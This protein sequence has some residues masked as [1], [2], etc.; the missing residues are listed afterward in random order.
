MEKEITVIEARDMIKSEGNL[1][2]IDLR[3]SNQFEKA[4]VEGFV[5]IPLNELSLKIP[6]LE[7]SRSTLLLCEDG[8]QSYQAMMLLEVTGF[9]VQVIRG[10]IRDWAKIIDPSL[11]LQ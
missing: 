1:Q 8:T 9:K 6:K 5:N 2:L 7:G 3:S 11:K 10:G 4:S